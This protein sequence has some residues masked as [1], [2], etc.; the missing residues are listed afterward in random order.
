MFVTCALDSNNLMWLTHVYHQMPLLIGDHSNKDYWDKG[1]KVFVFAL[2]LNR[3]GMHDK[4][5][6]FHCPRILVLC[7]LLLLMAI[8]VIN[9][10]AMNTNL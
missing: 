8:T 10:H 2:A 9:V 3:L 6:C 4:H 1:N 5:T 7:S